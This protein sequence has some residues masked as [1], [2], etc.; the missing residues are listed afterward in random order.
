MTGIYRFADR[1]FSVQTTYAYFHRR[2]EAFRASGTPE[3]KIT[4]SK[5]DIAFAK[6]KAYDLHT[7]EVREALSLP[8]PYWENAAVHDSLA[9]GMAD[10]GTVWLHGA[11][12]VFGD[13]GYLFLGGS[14]A[15]CRRYASCWGR[16]WNAAAWVPDAGVFLLRADGGEKRLFTA[17]FGESPVIRD[18]IAFTLRG[19]GILNRDLDEP[20]RLLSA[21]EAFPLL[22]MQSCDSVDSRIRRKISVLDRNVSHQIP[23][24]QLPPL[25]L[26]SAIEYAYH[27]IQES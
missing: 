10:F 6:E 20:P 12:I 15:C 22:L 7:A 23:C 18:N 4:V 25:T 21:A 9:Q 2:S 24:W 26:P 1:I 5:A 8:A 27:I 3:R 13:E 19:I 16:V 11:A 14:E 17:P